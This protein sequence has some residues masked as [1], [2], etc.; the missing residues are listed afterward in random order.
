MT[1]LLDHDVP[2]EIDRILVHAG[3][4]VT[5]LTEVL[6]ATSA[7]AKVLQFA[8]AQQLILVTCNRDDFLH[9]ARLGS[10]AGIIILIRRRTRIMEC[11]NRLAYATGAMTSCQ[12]TSIQP[13]VVQEKYSAMDGIFTRKGDR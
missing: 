5:R 11:A 12:Q 1:F 8:M 3:H 2:A 7:D 6:P 9:L 13:I 10:H 4:Q